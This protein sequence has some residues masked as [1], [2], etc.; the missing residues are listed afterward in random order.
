MPILRCE[1]LPGVEGFV[2]LAVPGPLQSTVHSHGKIP[3]KIAIGNDISR[4]RMLPGFNEFPQT[5]FVNGIGGFS[6]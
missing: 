5:P 1:S 6:C 4:I 3:S 2:G